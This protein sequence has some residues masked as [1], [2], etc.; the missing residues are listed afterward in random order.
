MGS[1]KTLHPKYILKPIQKRKCLAGK[2]QYSYKVR[3]G[4][5]K[6]V[7]KNSGPIFPKRRGHWTL[8]ELAAISWDQPISPVGQPPYTSVAPQA[9]HFATARSGASLCARVSP[10][11]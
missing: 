10:W 5:I 4:H 2:K 1:L 3:K 9:R 8:K 6:H 7:C 11:S